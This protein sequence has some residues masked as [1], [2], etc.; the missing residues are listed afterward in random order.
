ME[1]KE[2]LKSLT[3][4]VIF[5]KINKGSKSES[6]Q[7]FLYIKQNE[8]IHLFMQ[9]SNPFEN[10]NL[11]AYDGKVITVKGYFNNQSFVVEEISE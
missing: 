3:G 8:I 2:E 5:Q 9:N 4:T 11:Q 6:M 10:T 7:P 1:N